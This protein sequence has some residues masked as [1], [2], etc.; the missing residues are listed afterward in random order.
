MVYTVNQYEVLLASKDNMLDKYSK[1]LEEQN[2]KIQS[3]QSLLAL[4]DQEISMLKKEKNLTTEP[5]ENY[6]S[7][8]V[9][10]TLKHGPIDNEV[11]GGNVYVD[12]TEFWMFNEVNTD[13]GGNTNLSEILPDS[14]GNLW[15]EA[16]NIN[17]VPKSTVV[18]PQKDIIQKELSSTEVQNELIQNRMEI[19][20]SSKNLVKTKDMS[21][22]TVVTTN[23]ILP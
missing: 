4:R 12:P 18:K 14:F 15:S 22:E 8:S 19:I 21:H 1:A 6:P 11:I 16:D 9:V 23:E 5:V 7:I 2:D 10:K 3:L 20:E 13:I 17:L